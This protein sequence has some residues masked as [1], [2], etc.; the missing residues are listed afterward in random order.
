GPLT[1]GPGGEAGGLD[2]L[3]GKKQAGGQTDLAPQHKGVSGWQERSVAD[4]KIG[5]APERERSRTRPA[6][7]EGQKI[8]VAIEPALRDRD[9]RAAERPATRDEHQ[10]PEAPIVGQAS[11]PGRPPDRPAPRPPAAPAAI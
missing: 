7:D 5:G 10:R 1:E 11:H 3:D 6:D 9:Q 8:A 2:G 4:V